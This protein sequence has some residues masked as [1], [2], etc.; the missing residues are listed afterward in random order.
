MNYKIILYFC[1]LLLLYQNVKSEVVV[2]INHNNI[3]NIYNLIAYNDEDLLL[4][5]NEN[6]YNF[7]VYEVVQIAVNKDIHFQGNHN[8]TILDF[9]NNSYG[10]PIYFKEC[11]GQT[12]TFENLIFRNYHPYNINLNLINVNIYGSD[13]YKINFKNCI[14]ENVEYLCDIFYPINKRTQKFYNVM[15]DNCIFR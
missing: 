14:F 2:N 9:T 7:P 15:F 6:S 11:K 3:R 12:L 8:M 1:I 5:F 13:N 10:L 4:E